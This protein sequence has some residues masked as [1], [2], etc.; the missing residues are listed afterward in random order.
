MAGKEAEAA[1]TVCNAIDITAPEFKAAQERVGETDDAFADAPVTSVAGALAKMRELVDLG[2]DDDSTSLDTRH[3]KTVTAFLEGFAGAPPVSVDDPAV[4]A[5][6]EYRVAKAADDAI[7]DKDAEAETPEY[8]ATG[9]RLYAAR[10]AVYNAVPTSMA[11]MAAKVHYFY[12]Y[13]ERG[14]DLWVPFDTMAKSMLPFLEAGPPLELAPDPVVTLFTK[15]AIIRD[16]ATALSASD[17]K[18]TDPEI[19]ARW[20]NALD[21]LDAVENQIMETPATS[22]Q[23][24]AIKIR[25]ASHHILEAGDVAKRYATPSRDI[26]YVEAD[27]GLGAGGL[28]AVSA[29]RDAERLAGVS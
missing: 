29:L 5:L 16:E 23:G 13:G 18:A 1:R 7:S 10:D 17:P 27:G 12:H 26:D 2:S 14:N 22:M 3:I 21:R 19:N 24:V 11:G 25:I 15:W 28:Y 8:Q 9:D 6:A 20:E 4:A